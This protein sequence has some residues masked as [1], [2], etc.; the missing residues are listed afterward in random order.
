MTNSETTGGTVRLAV[1]HIAGNVGGLWFAH[2][3][4]A[5]AAHAKRLAT[6]DAIENCV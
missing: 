1:S 4:A 6:T 3:V 2:L 5:D